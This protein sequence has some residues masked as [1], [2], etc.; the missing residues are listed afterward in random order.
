MANTGILHFTFHILAA[1]EDKPESLCR[2]EKLTRKTINFY[3]VNLLD[4]ENL[5]KVFEKVNFDFFI[6]NN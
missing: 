6:Y 2:V 4:E 1:V 5:R 3:A